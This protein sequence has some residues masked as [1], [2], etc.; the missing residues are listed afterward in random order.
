MDV[1]GEKKACS[2]RLFP[3]LLLLSIAVGLYI[4]SLYSYLLFHSLAELFSVSIAFSIFILAWNSRRFFQ[5]RFLQ[6]IAVGYSFSGIIDLIHTLAYKG[7]SVFEG[8]GTNLPTQLWIAARYVQAITLFIAA[9]MPYEKNIQKGI[10]YNKLFLFYGAIVSLLLWSIF[11]GI[12]PACF[13]EGFGLTTFK[14]VSEYVISL[15]VFV[16]ILQLYRKREYLE[17]NIFRLIILSFASLIGSEMAFTLYRDAY[18]F[19]NLLGHYIKILSYY[20]IYK[21]IVV[22]G[23][24]EPYDLL[25]RDLKK[26][27]DHLETLVAARTS[28]LKAELL[29]RIRAEKALSD[30]EERFRAITTAAT[31]KILSCQLNF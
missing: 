2:K 16:A 8:Y 29:E 28:K 21:A 15:L 6:I 30:S 19:F 27:R 7:I 14:K 22:K 4:S 26:H 5:N 11:S 10:S 23:L 18:G 17:S 1:G 25:F 20:F 12:F 9:S 13:I 31:T 24:M 3:V